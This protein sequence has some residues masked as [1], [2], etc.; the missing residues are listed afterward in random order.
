MWFPTIFDIWLS[1]IFGHTCEEPDCWG[2]LPDYWERPLQHVSCRC[3]CHHCP[4]SRHRDWWVEGYYVS[5][6]SHW[7]ERSLTFSLI[8]KKI[9]INFKANWWLMINLFAAFKDRPPTAANRAQEMK[10]NGPEESYL[11]SIKNLLTNKYNYEF[12][13]Q[14]CINSILSMINN[15][16]QSLIMRVLP[17]PYQEPLSQTS[18]N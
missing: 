15:H 1:I 14:I 12:R 17:L 18:K 16:Q 5:C 11:S 7:L 3:H 8:Y 9:K 4:S 6:M 2:E 10:E 13:R